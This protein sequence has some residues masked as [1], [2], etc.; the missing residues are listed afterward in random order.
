M[1]GG[2]ETREQSFSAVPSFLS[3]HERVKFRYTAGPHS[4]WAFLS[5]E[6]ITGGGDRPLTWG[7][8]AQFLVMQPSLGTHIVPVEVT[9]T[10]CP[11]GLLPFAAPVS[12]SRVNASLLQLKRHSCVDQ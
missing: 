8:P 4:L 10:L 11:R 1:K 7:P 2:A 5:T 12:G 9:S 6:V 3:L